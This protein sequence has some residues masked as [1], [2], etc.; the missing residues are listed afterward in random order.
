MSQIED[1]ALEGPK[2]ISG[3][4]EDGSGI[5]GVS[6]RCEARGSPQRGSTDVQPAAV[7]A[8]TPAGCLRRRRLGIGAAPTGAKSAGAPRK[9][10]RKI[11]RRGTLTAELAVSVGRCG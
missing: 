4:S 9:R 10:G 1:N 5:A 8:E 2:T 3:P 7:Q 6:V 11:G